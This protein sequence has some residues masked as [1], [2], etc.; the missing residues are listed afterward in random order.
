MH[1]LGKA[2]QA[3]IDGGLDFYLIVGGSPRQRIKMGLPPNV[4]ELKPLL[5]QFTAVYFPFSQPTPKDDVLA[6]VL[7]FDA[8]YDCEI[9][10]TAIM[11]FIVENPEAESWTSTSEQEAKPQ[12]ASPPPDNVRPFRPRK[13]KATPQSG[14]A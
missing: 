13:K 3:A 1:P 6:C 11:R 5:L 7:S 8:L 10:Y 4:A 14:S 12:E 9:P 2:I